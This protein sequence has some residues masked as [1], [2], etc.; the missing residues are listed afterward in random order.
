MSTKDFKEGMIAGAKP[1]GDKLDQLADI[2]ESVVPELQVGIDGIATVTNALIDDVE[3]HDNILSA[4]E[5][6]RIYDLDSVMDVSSL[7]DE[8]KEFLVAVLTELANILPNVADLQKKY[9]L[10]ICSVANVT[11]PQTALNLACI[12]NIENMKTQK[13]VLRH[14]M[15][16]LFIGEQSYSFLEAYAEDVFCYFSVN[17]RGI[18]EI[19][20]A[21]DRVFNAMGIDGIVSRYTFAS[22]YEEPVTESSP[23][24]FEDVN[25]REVEYSPDV[26]E[27][28]YTSLSDVVQINEGEVLTY[29]Y[30]KVSITGIINVDGAL[31]FED[32]EI[33]FSD[34]NAYP[35]VSVKGEVSFKNCELMDLEQSPYAS[36]AVKDRIGKGVLNGAVSSKI[37]FENCIIREVE[38][39]ISTEGS[40]SID[41][42]SIVNPGIRFASVMVSKPSVIASTVV[43]FT[44][45]LNVPKSGFDYIARDIILALKDDTATADAILKIENCH[46]S[47]ASIDTLKEVVPVSA[48]NAPCSILNCEFYNFARVRCITFVQ[49]I[50]NTHFSNCFGI[51]ADKIINSSANQCTYIGS[52][53]NSVI[54]NCDFDDCKGIRLPENST[55]RNCRIKNSRG[56]IIDASKSQI[57]DCIFSNI[58][59][60]N[61][62]TPSSVIWGKESQGNYPLYL[63]NTRVENCVFD[64]IELLDNAFLIAGE[65]MADSKL[66]FSIE[67]CVF[68]NCYTD[69]SDKLII[70]AR[71]HFGILGTKQREFD[72]TTACVGLNQVKNGT[73]EADRPV[74][75][76]PNHTGLL[77]G[78]VIGS[79]LTGGLGAFVGGAVGATIDATL[80]KQKKS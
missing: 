64:G 56:R 47:A 78:A 21:I 2:V 54:D 71:E 16:F 37:S 41:S 35:Y 27:W 5:R 52:R 77:A 6:K 30:Q 9:L 49:T 36:E 15:E 12:E 72:P 42:C 67:N 28:G 34:E 48:A 32:C 43:E 50:A 44:S 45:E 46:F 24:D 62:G 53:S 51:I 55:L 1:F 10:S 18:D 66:P 79:V 75:D 11:A 80:N 13:V 33:F 68:R 31:H 14:V 40:L 60:W 74:V 39:F 59:K 76:S 69:R 38:H 63:R 3:N 4:Y 73:L 58:R 26:S 61:K 19:K 23:V 7:D 65:K 20:S 17:Q 8:E 70:A 29:R 22:N 25:E 57:V